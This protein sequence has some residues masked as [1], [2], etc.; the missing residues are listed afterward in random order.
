MT[1][2]SMDRRNDLR[3]LRAAAS[4]NAYSP[5]PL[6]HVYVQLDFEQRFEAARNAEDARGFLRSVARAAM[7]A[8][9]LA[10][11][12]DGALMEVQGS[13]LHVALPSLHG[14]YAVFRFS[15]DLH[16]ALHAL[17]S[18][19]DAR[20]RGWRMTSDSGNTLVVRGRGVHGDDSLV[21]LGRAANRPAKHLF[22][23]LEL[24][25]ENR[26]LKRFWLGIRDPRTGAWRH[27]RLED[28]PSRNDAATS[29]AEKARS[30]DPT[31]DFG[32]PTSRLAK[33]SAAPIGP[34]WSPMSPSADRPQSYFGWVMRADLDGF[35]ARVEAC[36]DNA[37][38][39]QELAVEFAAIMN[40]A[41]EFVERHRE[42]LVQLPWAGDNFTAAALFSTERQYDAAA[43]DRL[44][45]LSLDFEKDMK[46]VASN[47]ELRGWAHGVAGGLPHGNSNC[48]VFVGAVIIDGRR[49]LVGAGEGFGRS[50]QAF[51][52][53]NPQASELV[54]Y[55]P[56]CKRLAARYK[57]TFERAVTH[58]GEQSSLYRTAKMSALLRA[59][60][61]EAA[62]SASILVSAPG[63]RPTP[64]IAR[65]YFEQ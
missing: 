32:R 40:A 62:G 18:R 33:A 20:V 10:D 30:A 28:L 38:L 61:K 8:A 42:T 34:A 63:R 1:Q 64:I 53:I 35:S 57:E 60:A 29:A 11:E 27:Q 4:A 47:A 46:A 39:L 55:E 56:D 5:V 24:A 49:F 36:F 14:E 16:R 45:E 17:F 26:K 59:R 37:Q 21:S 19:P 25:E 41:A 7:A 43:P 3:S 2:F 23:Q 31:I 44:V 48:N 51:G 6:A 12:L 13:V 50:A 9:T 54:M 22:A 58:H 65:P 52:D 15:A